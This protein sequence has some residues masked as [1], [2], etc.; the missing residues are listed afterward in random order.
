[1]KVKRRIN[2]ARIVWVICL[3]LFLIVILL[4]VIDYKV[5]YQYLTHNYLY[6]YE[7]TG[8]LCVTTVEDNQKLLYSSYDCGFEE[9]PSY[10][11][12]VGDDYVLL[13]GDNQFLLYNY[14]KDVIISR[15]YED[16]EFIDS[17]AIIVKKND[18]FGIIGIDNKVIVKPSYEEIGIH[19]NGFLT[20]YNANSIV[21]LKKDKYGAISYKDGKLEVE[22][23]YTKDNLDE[24]LGTM[25]ID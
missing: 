23:K 6:F 8:D 4:M 7:C 13:F 22:F 11:K 2:Y 19:T 3:F 25:K 10:K 12:N 24:L 5:H 20:G 21:A 15:D 14:K 18:V 17:N 1:M 9:C 16:Y